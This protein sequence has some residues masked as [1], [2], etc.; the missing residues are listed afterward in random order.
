MRHTKGSLK[1]GRVIYIRVNPKDCMS[2]IDV[3]QKAGMNLQ[4]ASFSLIASAA[5]SSALES[6]RQNGIIPDR[7]GFE[8]TDMMKDYPMTDKQERARA[9]AIN[10]TFS[11]AG[12]NI[13]I[14]PVISGPPVDRRKK[15]RFE[16][17]A[18]KKN[19]APESMDSDDEVE[20]QGLIFE[21]NPL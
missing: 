13:N 14:P 10:R 16:E 8:Y 9:L 18:R 5:L 2:C 19:A 15:L 20:L 4:R 7:E 17:L 1:P 11:L 6:F 3:V 21:L 12:S